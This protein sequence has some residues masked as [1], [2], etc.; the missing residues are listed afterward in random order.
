[1]KPSN[2]VLSTA[3][4]KAV[5]NVVEQGEEKIV[6]LRVSNGKFVIEGELS[7]VRAVM[8]K[9]YY[10]DLKNTV[11]ISEE[12]G[13][14]YKVDVLPK[15]KAPLD[16]EEDEKYWTD[17][18]VKEQVKLYFNI[19]KWKKS[20]GKP[21]WWPLTLSFDKYEHWSYAKM[22]TN[23]KILKAI[24]E[25]YGYDPESHC[26]DP[27][28]PKP[29][30]KKSKK[31]VQPEDNPDNIQKENDLNNSM[32][33][34][35]RNNRIDDEIPEKTDKV[36]N[37][38]ILRSSKR[39]R[40]EEN[41]STSSFTQSSSSQFTND[42]R[43]PSYTSWQEAPAPTTSPAASPPPSPTTSTPPATPLRAAPPRS[44]SPF[45]TPPSPATSP[46]PGLPHAPSSPHSPP[47]PA[48]P[49]AES[50]TSSEAEIDPIV[51][52][53]TRR[54]WQCT[55]NCGKNFATMMQMMKHLGGCKK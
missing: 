1:M 36:K 33:D 38:G 18:S 26:E 30:V 2:F 39:K 21:V 9:E 6:C 55:A 37:K 35:Q 19:L 31:K 28:S 29:K 12:K 51:R 45:I 52:R 53:S 27:P 42:R 25:H 54:K 24:L 34:N 15:L 17:K 3:L 40:T 16:L 20:L 8:A 22:R 32:D 5:K 50:Y 13:T 44:P 46:A 14:Y 10:T 23:K 11:L 48:S 41:V 7:G 47:A 43:L 49:R 4:D